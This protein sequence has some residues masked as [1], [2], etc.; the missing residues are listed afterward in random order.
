VREIMIEMDNIPFADKPVKRDYMWRDIERRADLFGIKA[1]LPAP[2][3]L[4]GFDLANQIAIL[5]EQQGW[6]RDYVIATYQLWFQHGQPAGQEPNLSKSLKSIGLNPEEVIGQALSEEIVA[7]YKLS[8]SRAR[9]LGIF[10]APSFVTRGELFWGDDRMEEAVLWH[11][12]QQ[13]AG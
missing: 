4:T 3:P 11:L 6:C 10:G 13:L 12:E 8:T 9:Q 1:K 7:A 5:G 2:Y